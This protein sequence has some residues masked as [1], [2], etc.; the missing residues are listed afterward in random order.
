MDE[1]ERHELPLGSLAWDGGK[2]IENEKNKLLTI[3]K[4]NIK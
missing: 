2:C 4:K 1:G 3:V